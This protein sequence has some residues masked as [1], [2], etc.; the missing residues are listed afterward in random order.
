MEQVHDNVVSDAY[1][2]RGVPQY[3]RTENDPGY[4]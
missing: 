2:Q 1:G 3:R 4:Y